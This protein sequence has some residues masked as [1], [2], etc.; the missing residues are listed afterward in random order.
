MVYLTPRRHFPT[1][2]PLAPERRAA[3]LDLA[4]RHGFA[5]VEEDPDAELTWE[6]QPHLPLA[7]EDAEGRVIHLGSLSQLLAAGLGLAY[8]VAP[9]SLLDRLARLGQRL[10]VEGDHVLEWAVA[11]LIRD[12]D[13]ERHLARSRKLL[14]ERRDAFLRGLAELGRGFEVQPC[15]GGQ[16]VWLRTPPGFETV[17]WV[18]T[19]L[20]EGVRVHPGSQYDFHGRRLAGLRL[21]FA[22]LDVCEARRALRVLQ[23][24]LEVLQAARPG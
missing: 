19:C 2:V 16:A 8:V 4:R 21:G 1:T 5:V 15:N 13:L 18:R 10:D 12:G 11:D 9:A 7:A 23:R 20:Q 24:G 14:R 3:V 17:A 22:Q 6:G